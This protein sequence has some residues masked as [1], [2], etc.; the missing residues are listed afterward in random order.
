MKTLVIIFKYLFNRKSIKDPKPLNA[1][2]L[3]LFAQ[4]HFRSI[5]K[6]FGVVDDH[7]LEIASYRIE[8]VKKQSPECLKTGKCIYCECSLDESVLSDAPC[9]HGCYEKMLSKEEWEDYKLK[10]NIKIIINDNQDN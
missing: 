2:T 6:K 8:Q 7:I 4:G 3:H 10:N 1:T 5:L 9:A